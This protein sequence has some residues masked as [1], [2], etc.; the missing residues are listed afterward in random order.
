MK[1]PAIA[2]AVSLRAVTAGG[3][4]ANPKVIIIPDGPVASPLPPMPQMVRRET[5]PKPLSPDP[6]GPFTDDDNYPHHVIL[7]SD[8][9]EFEYCCH[10]CGTFWLYYDFAEM[11]RRCYQKRNDKDAMIVGAPPP[12]SGPG[13]PA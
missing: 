3:N 11:S 5:F 1:V 8:D 6:N 13:A 4:P 12:N 9:P 7:K 10:I 2:A